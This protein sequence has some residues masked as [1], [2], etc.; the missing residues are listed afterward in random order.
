M[1]AEDVG[2]VALFG[3]GDALFLLKLVNGGELVAKACGG[4]KLLGFG[5][6]VHAGGEGALELGGTA[7]EKE[8]GVADGLA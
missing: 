4:F 5:G 3:G 6:G 2:V 1:V 7:F 8:L